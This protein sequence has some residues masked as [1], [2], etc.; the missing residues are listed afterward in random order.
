[1]SYYNIG[2]NCENGN[3]SDISKKIEYLI[4]DK[5]KRIAMGL[6]NRKLAEEKFDRRKS[7]QEIVNLF[8]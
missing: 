5:E 7:Y 1:V 4:N 6:A 8:N 3:V 2:Y